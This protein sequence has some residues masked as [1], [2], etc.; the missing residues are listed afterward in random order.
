MPEEYAL[1]VE[2]YQQPSVDPMGY[3]LPVAQ[4]IPADI[5]RVIINTS[6]E[7]DV[8]STRDEPILHT[9]GKQL[10]AVDHDPW[11]IGKVV[12]N[13][14][15]A[16]AAATQAW[17]DPAQPRN[18]LW[19]ERMV[20]AG[21]TAAGN[22]MSGATPQW[23]VDPETGDVHTSPQMIEAGLDTAA[24]AGTGGLAGTT[25]AT[26]GS[27]P[28]LRPA[29]KHNG[30]I[31]KGKEGQ[32]HLDVL[33][34]ELEADF[35]QK[36]LSGE[37]ISHYNFGFM[38]HKGQFLNR[39]AALDYAVK[40]GLVDPNAGQYGA[41]T[42]TL[43]S[44]SSKPGIAIEAMKKPTFYSALEHNVNN[45]GQAKMTGD[46]WLGTLANKPGVKPEE[47]QW[48]GLK[49]FLEENKGK[50]VTKEQIQEHLQN[51]KVELKEI[52]KGVLAIP[53]Q[54]LRDQGL[55]EDEIDK[56]IPFDATK[57]NTK[58]SS[59]QLPGGENYR[60]MLM[61]LP[62]KPK[63]LPTEAQYKALDAK[64]GTG[65][66]LTPKEMELHQNYE[67]MLNGLPNRDEV[68]PYKSSHW[69]EPNILAHVRMN[70][71]TIE[72]KK[73]LHVEEIQSDWHQQGREKGYIKKY[74]PNDLEALPDN[75]PHA[76]DPS[77]FYY[78]KAPDNIY[79]ISKGKV[80]SA[81]EAK[82]YVAY[83]KTHGG[84]TIPDAPFKKT[85][86]E[87]ALKRMLREAA[88]KGY[89]RLSWTPGEAQA[90]RYDL[91]RSV[92]SINV[93]PEH[94][95]K[96]VEINPKGGKQIGVYV[97][98]KGN[99]VPNAGYDVHAK[100][101]E[102]KALSDI[103]GKETADKIL[104]LEKGELAGENLKIGGEGMKGFYDKM[105]PNAL[106]KMGKEHGV[107]VKQGGV[108]EPKVSVL[109]DKEHFVNSFE[110]KA[111]AESW[112]NRTFTPETAS[113]YKISE[114]SHPV[115]YIDIPQSLKDT[116]LRK[117]QPLFSSAHPGVTFSQVN[118]D[119]W[120]KK[121]ATKEK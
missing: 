1:P 71:R 35:N 85:W 109:D 33:P 28:F 121:N 68:A 60:E 112:L 113:K 21:I 115:H 19:P 75:S 91:S 59:Y 58:Y 73:S 56:R 2:G 67:R 49:E 17:Q 20:R 44:D 79:Q 34:K 87:L 57:D 16:P 93:K 119:P 10:K 120:E 50:P 32:Q 77:R 66:Q 52:E 76:T 24:L 117:G 99:V 43:L 30:K 41:L 69:D 72:G 95:N 90:A 18:Q 13:L 110:N 36:A 105:I 48:T 107:K 102:G 22:V 26:L 118:H 39:E 42:S 92:D 53:R 5:P 37:D 11:A 111:A 9:S 6:P 97:N 64:F 46:Q 12:E 45:I 29:L 51:N 31:Y 116:V 108:N 74:G 54:K 38:N 8:I 88:E 40:E 3:A 65:E 106:E 101:Y 103:V 104:K 82:E 80:S 89:D 98:D 27:G 86:H 23:A 4:P 114:K 62:G 7:P 61:T 84:G 63:G 14:I 96:L 78:V 94:G 81:E 25:E 15:G 100:P 83:N 55:S 70:D 47:L